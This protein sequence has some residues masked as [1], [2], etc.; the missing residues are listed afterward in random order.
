MAEI[1]DMRVTPEAIYLRFRLHGVFDEVGKVPCRYGIYRDN[2]GSIMFGALSP[3]HR[4]AFASV[5]WD[6]TVEKFLKNAVSQRYWI[7][8]Y[9][10]A[11]AVTEADG[12]VWWSL[13]ITAERKME[14]TDIV[15]GFRKMLELMERRLE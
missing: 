6:E 9:H 2:G 10:Y 14:N 1:S 5:P 3:D 13:P 12:G 11:S 8:R 4:L 15:E 7:E